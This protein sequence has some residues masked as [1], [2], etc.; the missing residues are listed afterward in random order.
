MI[1][2]PLVQNRSLAF[3]GRMKTVSK[4]KVNYSGESNGILMHHSFKNDH[5]TP[6]AMLPAVTVGSA[7]GCSLMSTFFPGGPS[8]LSIP[9]I[10]GP[11]LGIPGA[12]WGVAQLMDRKVTIVEKQV[13]MTEAEELAVMTP[14]EKAHW[15]IDQALEKWQSIRQKQS[16]NLKRLEDKKSSLQGELAQLESSLQK[17]TQDPHPDRQQLELKLTAKKASLAE[18]EALRETSA[19]MMLTL[20]G[21]MKLKEAS[22]Y[23]AKEKL[24]M[25]HL[26]Q[27]V[28]NL[29]QQLQGMDPGSD[30]ALS[31]QPVLLDVE[32]QKVELEGIMASIQTALSVE[33]S[34]RSTDLSN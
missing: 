30:P 3:S 2:T 32:K 19:K 20:E 8:P 26:R 28:L 27:D 17:M 29:H 7:T 33:E 22:L 13:P 15:E 12:S 14:R 6:P 24:D 10:L 4:K 11:L 21:R 1:Q 16:D 5:A 18:M 34:L 9:V 31:Q 23:E 25:M